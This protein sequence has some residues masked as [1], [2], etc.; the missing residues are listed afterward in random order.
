[1]AKVFLQRMG[2]LQFPLYFLVTMAVL[3][4]LYYTLPDWFIESVLVRF[5]A[6]IPGATILDWMTPAYAVSSEQTRII[7]PLVRLNVLKG[8]EGTEVLLILY[9]AIFAVFRPL[10]YS[11]PGI[12][13]GTLLVF[14]LNQLRI[15]AL[16]FIAAYEKN[17]FE[18]V[19]GFL[20]PVVMIAAASGFFLLWMRWSES[21]RASGP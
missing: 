3:T 4:G 11:L 10:R 16:F 2:N 17:L 1:M 8:C 12:L 13:A 18:L 20:A 15:V 5:F 7:S 9:A 19:H 6:V 21:G 14:V